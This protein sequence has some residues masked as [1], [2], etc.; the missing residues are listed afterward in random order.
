MEEMKK[1]ALMLQTGDEMNTA[2]PPIGQGLSSGKGNLIHA[3]TLQ[4][5][6]AHGE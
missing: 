5:C 6:L 1:S 2:G 4:I 3:D